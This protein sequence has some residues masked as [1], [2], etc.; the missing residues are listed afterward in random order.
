MPYVNFISRGEKHMVIVGSFI[1]GTSFL[2][3]PLSND[4]YFRK[5]SQVRM[6]EMVARNANTENLM[7]LKI[8]FFVTI[9]MFIALLSKLNSNM[10]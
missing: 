7:S 5:S 3:N 2:L 4:S 10:A 9:I 1:I 8:L 6:M